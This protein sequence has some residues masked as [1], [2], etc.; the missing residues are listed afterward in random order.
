MQTDGTKTKNG[1]P[2]LFPLLL[3]AAQT[4]IKEFK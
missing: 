1:A 4:A 2:A 3:S